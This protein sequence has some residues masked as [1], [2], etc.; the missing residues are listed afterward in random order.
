MFE[1]RGFHTLTAG[2]GEEALEILKH[3]TVHLA[4]FDMHM[5]RLSGLDAIRRLKQ[6]YGSLPCI[7][8]SA[9]ADELLMAEAREARAFDVLRKPVTRDR[10]INVVQLAL[11]ASYDRGSWR[12]LLGS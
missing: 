3:E 1:P 10:V 8:L 7:L 2:D 4:L 5:P 11:D 9:E 6:L 12:G